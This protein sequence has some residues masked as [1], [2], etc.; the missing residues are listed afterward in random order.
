MSGTSV[1]T[2]E[3]VCFGYG[4]RP[5]LTGV[6]FG[7]DAGRVVGLV[8]PNGAGKSTALR[9][10]TGL[11]RPRSGAVWFDGRDLQTV[12][13]REIARAIALVPQEA[14]LPAGFTAR[15]TVA[16][17]RTPYLGWFAGPKAADRAA[18]RRALDLVAAARVRGSPGRIALRRRAPPALVG[19]C[20]GTTAAGAA[21]GRTCRPPGP[22]ARP[23]GPRHRLP[24]GPR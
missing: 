23:G 8:G 14:A 12:P 13:R 1:L 21:A 15:E 24:A 18:E 9:L 3:H 19:A 10:V 17:G 7:V 4:D 5:I 11:L 20:A 2:L 6:S 22:R 16:M